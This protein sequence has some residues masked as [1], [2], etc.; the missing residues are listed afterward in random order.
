MRSSLK[1]SLFTLLG[2]VIFILGWVI[3]SA[4]IDETVMI[5]PDPVSTI[6]ETFVL[7]SKSYVYKCMG[8]SVLRTVI[9][10]AIAFI[11]SLVLGILAGTIPNLKHVF[12]PIFSVMKSIPTA[13]LVFLFLVIMGAK[14]APILMVTLISMPILYEAVVRG[15]EN[16][17]KNL[18]NSARIDGANYL[19]R[20]LKIQ[21]PLMVPYLMVGVA[22]SFSL[23]FKIEIMAEVISGNT[24]NG[25]GSAILAAQRT[26]PTNMV[27][28][29]AY[30]LVTILI[31]ALISI[32]PMV[33]ET[34]SPLKK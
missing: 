34:K 23:S 4:L 1:K 15:F 13:S 22:S 24:T 16:V 6:R 18:L 5:F 20:T 12:S 28:I 32:I 7:L 17:D 30:S 31:V 14:N 29:F 11:L 27:P 25:L 3:I 2:I 33:I 21:L 9:G 26:D 19:T 8:Q 10:F